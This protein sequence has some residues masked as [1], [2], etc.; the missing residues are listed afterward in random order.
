MKKITPISACHVAINTI[1]N[2]ESS[3][4]NLGCR[5]VESVLACNGSGH[6]GQNTTGG[7]KY[8]RGAMRLQKNT[9][10]IQREDTNIWLDG[11]SIMHLLPA[12]SL[13]GY[14]RNAEQAK[15]KDTMR[16]I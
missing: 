4:K 1:S 5:A 8:E 9:A 14:A 6:I 15:R 3:E 12:N 16:T 2:G 7:Q 10:M 11:L 13:R